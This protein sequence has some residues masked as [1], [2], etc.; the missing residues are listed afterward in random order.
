MLS[1]L[2]PYFTVAAL[3]LFSG[4]NAAALG[5][6]PTYNG[7]KIAS[8][9]DLAIRD[10]A[11]GDDDAPLELDDIIDPAQLKQLGD[12]DLENI[13]KFMSTIPDEIVDQGTDATEKWVQE[14]LGTGLD[15]RDWWNPS[16][17][18]IGWKIIKCS[19]AISLF[20]VENW[21]VFAKLG[22]LNKIRKFKKAIDD[23]GG[24]K[25]AAKLL[26]EKPKGKH[27]KSKLKKKK[28]LEKL[29]LEIVGVAVMQAYCDFSK[30]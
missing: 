23:A 8:P 2:L 30:K 17:W 15:A 22:K 4:I 16:D 11:A 3:H 19:G 29:A 20:V 7:N 18:G 27:R 14:H 13:L 25:K 26:L 5:T 12:G 6:F 10:D 1:H 21:S 28:A 24:Y 9:N